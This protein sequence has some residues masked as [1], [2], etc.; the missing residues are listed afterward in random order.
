MSNELH[1]FFRPEFLNRVDEILNF[2]ALS[3]EDIVKIVDIQLK[4][5]AEKLSAASIELEIDAA[6]KL[7]LAE[8]G[9]DVAF[10]AR[11][12]KRTVIKL[13]E[14]PVS[15]MMIAGDLAAGSKLHISLNSNELIFKAE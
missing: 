6:A 4:K 5:F 10:G 14:T 8:Q 11:P 1:K 15:R 12:L 7:Y 3:K 13:L 2:H 9:Y